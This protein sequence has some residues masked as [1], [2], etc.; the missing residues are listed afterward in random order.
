MNISRIALFCGLSAVLSFAGITINISG[1]GGKKHKEEPPPPPPPPRDIDQRLC[2]NDVCC[3][4]HIDGR[5]SKYTLRCDRPT[6]KITLKLNSSRTSS[7]EVI[8]EGHGKLR[9]GLDYDSQA[10]LSIKAKRKP[11]YN[12]RLCDNGNCCVI[13]QDP[14]NF[15]YTLSCEKPYERADLLVH[16]GGRKDH[17]SLSDRGQLSRELLKSDDVQIR[18]TNPPPPSKK[19]PHK[20]PGIKN[21][22]IND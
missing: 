17:Y 10:S 3:D 14:Y 9:T 16:S 4:L 15:N 1:N 18:L 2:D 6:E 5:S 13:D 12:K 20:I 11:N 19:G 22:S 21:R 8:K 7:N